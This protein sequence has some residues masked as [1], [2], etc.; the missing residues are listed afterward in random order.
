MAITKETEQVIVEVVGKYKNIQIAD[1]TII[2]EDG[3]QI[4][5]SRH[6]RA[7]T[8][9]MDI[10]GESDEIKGIANTVWTDEVKQ[11]L[12]DFKAAKEAETA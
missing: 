12:V 8:S 6:R 2:K 4:S 11:L 3:V 7:L 9:D 5:R 1:D 10:S